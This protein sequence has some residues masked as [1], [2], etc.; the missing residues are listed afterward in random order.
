MKLSVLDQSPVPSGADAGTALR[1]SIDLAR[2]CEALGYH[3][4]WVAEHHNMDGLAG[5]A[6]EVLVA[7]IAE[8][9]TTMRVG[10]GG[11]MLSH[12]PP[13]KVAETFRILAALNPR[14]IDLG[15]GRAPGSDGLTAYA[16]TLADRPIDV[17]RFPAMVAE[18]DAFLHGE[19]SPD[20]PF[21]DRVRAV[22]SGAE[23]PQLWALA[24]STGSAAIAAHFGLPLGFAHFIATGDGPPIVDWYRAN[25]RPSPRWPEPV[26]LVSA[27]ALCAPTTAEAERLADC[28]RLWRER[29]LSG[30]IPS[31]ADVARHGVPSRADLPGRSPMILGDPPA[32]EHGLRA[33]AESYHA[34]ELMVVS[35][36][37]DHADRV[38]SYELIAHQFGLSSP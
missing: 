33:L 31:P 24:S 7:L 6:P 13:L 11:V 30:P 32:V 20:S 27:S 5:A 3:R 21:G 9:T 37:W 12:Y 29:G 19:M 36:C 28:V 16:L 18:L 8:A 15:I 38:R 23:S 2:R 26:V 1:N 35:I 34:D 25:Y 17:D 4:F 14:R 22:P 10:T